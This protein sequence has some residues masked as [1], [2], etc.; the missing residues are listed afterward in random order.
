[1]SS[2]NSTHS[3]CVLYAEKKNLRIL[4]SVP[5]IG[6]FYMGVQTH[7]SQGNHSVRV[8]QGKITTK[9]SEKWYSV[10]Q[11]SWSWGP[12]PA[13]ESGRDCFLL[14]NIAWAHAGSLVLR[15]HYWI[16]PRKWVSCLF[17]CFLNQSTVFKTSN[18]KKNTNQGR[19]VS[20]RE[21]SGEQDALPTDKS[22]LLLFKHCSRV[23]FYH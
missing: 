4:E 8:L 11:I 22:G 14:W 7:G 23:S 9:E 21:D 13:C 12:L 5:Q 18:F 16:R 15:K 10:K 1:M 17:V 19:W 6:W 2:F 3:T 20:L